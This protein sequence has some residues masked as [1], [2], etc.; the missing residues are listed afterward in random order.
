MRFGQSRFGEPLTWK[1]ST[2]RSGA[3]PLVGFPADRGGSGLFPA[4]TATRL[5]SAMVVS[6]VKALSLARDRCTQPAR[7]S[8]RTAASGYRALHPVASPAL[9]AEEPPPHGAHG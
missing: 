2:R 4:A 5:A 8:A 3:A 9:R 7:L 1:F 6:L